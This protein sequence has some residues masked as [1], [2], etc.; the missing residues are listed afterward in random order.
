[1]GTN[2]ELSWSV[3]SVA[4][5]LGMR[6]GA[7]LHFHTNLSLNSCCIMGVVFKISFF[8]LSIVLPN[9]FQ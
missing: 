9:K 4:G 8:F 3:G 1:M 2:L 6:K 5:N 7:R